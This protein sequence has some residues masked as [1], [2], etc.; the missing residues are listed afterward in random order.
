MLHFV[1]HGETVCTLLRHRS[2]Y[3]TI[4]LLF[5]RVE[6]R[7]NKGPPSLRTASRTTGAYTSHKMLADGTKSKLSSALS[8]QCSGSRFNQPE[9]DGPRLSL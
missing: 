2:E 3:S 9:T 1:A 7:A 6:L 8:H 5:V 4:I